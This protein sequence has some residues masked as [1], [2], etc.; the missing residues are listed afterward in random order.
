MVF[1]Q[2]IHP[3]HT[4][5][6]YS[7]HEF[8]ISKEFFELCKERHIPWRQLKPNC[9]YLY[10]YERQTDIIGLG[11]REEVEYVAGFDWWE[12]SDIQ[13]H[14]APPV[15]SKKTYGVDHLYIAVI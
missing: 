8:Q 9:F 2:M 7:H 6:Y 3:I 5:S 13:L 12:T 14:G 4:E 1:S 10:L 15:G 11:E